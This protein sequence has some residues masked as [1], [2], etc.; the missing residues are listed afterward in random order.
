MQVKVRVGGGRE[1]SSRPGDWKRWQPRRMGP[2]NCTP[3][4]D[5]VIE[6]Y[7]LWRD[8]EFQTTLRTVPPNGLLETNKNLSQCILPDVFTSVDA[9]SLILTTKYQAQSQMLRIKCGAN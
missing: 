7:S 1:V 4:Q 2:K 3:G 9:F 5:T 8:Y 6:G